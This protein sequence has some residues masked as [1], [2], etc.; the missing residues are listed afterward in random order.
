MPISRRLIPATA[1][2]SLTLSFNPVPS[3][4][5]LGVGGGSELETLDFA[6][7]GFGEF[8][9]EAHFAG[10]F[11]RDEAGFAMFA[12]FGSELVGLGTTGAQSDVGDCIGEAA[13]V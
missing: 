9:A 1:V 6:G 8:A 10:N 7:D 4:S 12:N 3:S 11:V 5:G 13:R 2:G